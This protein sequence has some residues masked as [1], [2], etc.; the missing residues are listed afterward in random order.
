MLIAYTKLPFL[1][2]FLGAGDYAEYYGFLN[3]Y[4]EHVSMWGRHHYSHLEDEKIKIQS[5]K[6]HT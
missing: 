3:S 2:S 1:E 5:P 6:S 4:Y